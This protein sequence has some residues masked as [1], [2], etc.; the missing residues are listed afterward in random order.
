[1]GT[2]CGTCKDKALELLHEF[3]HIYGG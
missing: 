1:M 2:V 3:A